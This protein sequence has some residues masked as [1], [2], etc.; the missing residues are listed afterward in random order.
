MR[1]PVT[2]AVANALTVAADVAGALAGAGTVTVAVALIIPV[3]VSVATD[4]AGAVVAASG[5]AI[6]TNAI[7]INLYVWWR[8]WR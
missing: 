5:V 3:D 8:R 2:T 4:G 1:Q 7:C 6:G